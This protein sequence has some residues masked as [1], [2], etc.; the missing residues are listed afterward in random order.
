MPSS[1][2]SVSL[3][4]CRLDLGISSDHKCLIYTKLSIPTKSFILLKSNIVLC[5]LKELRKK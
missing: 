3:G 2:L 5:V 4:Q 1:N